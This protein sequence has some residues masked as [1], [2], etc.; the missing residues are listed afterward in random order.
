MESE[1]GDSDEDGERSSE[2]SRAEEFRQAEE[3]GAAHDIAGELDYY[4]SSALRMSTTLTKLN[5]ANLILKV[6]SRCL[7]VLL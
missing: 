6:R 4:V 5:L 7:L 2:D 3:R 1:L